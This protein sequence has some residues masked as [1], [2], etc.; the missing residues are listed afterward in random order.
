VDRRSISQ[1]H[2]ATDFV[3]RQLAADMS[4]CRAASVDQCPPKGGAAGAGQARLIDDLKARR[5]MLGWSV[6][7]VSDRCGIDEMSLIEWECGVASPRLDPVERWAA[8]L[9]FHFQL[10]PIEGE[11]RRGLRVDWHARRIAVDGTPVRL[12]P[13]EWKALERLARSPGELVTHRALFHH[14]YGDEGQYRAQS[15]AIRVLITKLRRLLPLQIEARWG[16]GYVLTGLDPSLPQEAAAR[17][18]DAA[19]VSRPAAA[20]ARRD[21]IAPVPETAMPQSTP[22]PVGR[23]MIE[24]AAPAMPRVAAPPVQRSPCRAEELGVIERFLAERGVTRCPDLATIQQSPLPTLVWDKVKRK[25]V[26]PSATGQGV[27]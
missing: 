22:A 6:K 7:D 27:G 15:T 4:L 1:L 25:W 23:E 24:L 2:T 10:V 16:K 3:T 5:Q 14:L 9:G 13:M 8:A 26:R 20:Q 19:A 18:G 12:T 21:R 17:D 11:A